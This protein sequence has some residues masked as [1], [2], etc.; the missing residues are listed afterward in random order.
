MNAHAHAQRISRR[1]FFSFFGA[2]AAAAA[3]PVNTTVAVERAV[4]YQSPVC[5]NCGRMLQIPQ[6]THRYGR[7]RIAELKQQLPIACP[8]CGWSGE[9]VCALPL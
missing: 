5:P 4:T 3:V 8:D 9:A 7:E 1:G 6:T 2:G